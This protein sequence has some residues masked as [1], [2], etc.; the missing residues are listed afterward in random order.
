MGMELIESKIGL[1]RNEIP[2]VIERGCCNLFS[3]KK[4]S[5]VLGKFNGLFAEFLFL[6]SFKT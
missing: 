5:N 2:D 3:Y 1:I 6:K 4:K